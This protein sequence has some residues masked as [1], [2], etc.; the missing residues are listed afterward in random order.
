M[1]T[2]LEAVNQ[3]PFPAIVFGIIALLIALACLGVV[4]G[5]GASRPHS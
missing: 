2:L 5:L 4:L 3:L 1:L